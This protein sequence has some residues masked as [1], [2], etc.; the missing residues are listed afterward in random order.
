LLV[1]DSQADY[2]AKEIKE[3]KNILFQFRISGFEF[4]PNAHKLRTANNENDALTA[5]R[6]YRVQ[7]GLALKPNPTKLFPIDGGVAK[8]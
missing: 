3:H 8:W 2:A 4:S 1:L 5:P 7:Y 6:V